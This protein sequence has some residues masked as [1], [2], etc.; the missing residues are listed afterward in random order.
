[1]PS[2][3][4]VRA[5]RRNEQPRGGVR[6]NC[7]YPMCTEHMGTRPP[8]SF[9]FCVRL[10]LH[11]SNGDARP[12]FLLHFAHTLRFHSH[13]SSARLGE[14]L[15]NPEG[16]AGS[17]ATSQEVSLHRKG[18]LRVL[19]AVCKRKKSGISRRN[20]SLVEPHAQGKTKPF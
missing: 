19:P 14:R 4:Q 10:G 17:S 1:M 12:R 7:A 18:L 16:Q 5:K 13:M 8:E 3:V 20:A 6:E 11:K 2:A 9:P 15:T